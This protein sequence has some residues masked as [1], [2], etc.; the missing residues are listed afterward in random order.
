MTDMDLAKLKN[1]GLTPREAEVLAWV[2]QGKSNNMIG[3]ILG[4]S[5]RTV[6]KHLERTFHKLGVESR[7]AA[8]TQ[9]LTVI[10]TK[11]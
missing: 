7:T 2:A 5:H 10:W 11:N 4:I 3:V 9:A 6:Q 8:A 1:L